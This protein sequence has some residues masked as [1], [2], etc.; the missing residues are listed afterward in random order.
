MSGS[1]SKRRR[2]TVDSL[3]Q[4]TSPRA[5]GVR[6]LV[7]AKE[8]N[9]DRVEPDPEQ[10][11]QTF[12]EQSLEELATSIQSEGVLQPIAVSYDDASDRYVIIHGERRWRAAKLAG[13][14]TVPAVV[15]D[16]P[17]ERRLVQQLME[18]VVRED[19][20]AVDRAAALRSLK[21]QMD[22]APWESVAEVVGIR[23]SRLFQLLSTE[24]LAE[25]V[26][27]RIRSGELSE[28]QTRSLQGLSPD[29][30]ETLADLIVAGDASE[31]TVRQISRELREDPEYLE[32][33]RDQL[34][35]RIT[36]L[37]VAHS[38]SPTDG[39]EHT[40]R[41]PV[42]TALGELFEERNLPDDAGNALSELA[43]HSGSDHGENSPLRQIGL[44][45]GR[46]VT[47]DGDESRSY[48]PRQ[49]RAL[50]AL[51]DLAL[52]KR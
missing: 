29:A 45:L 20:N 33:D 50:R 3:F 28:K 8:I 30:Q 37:C 49:L 25:P 13:L 19:L 5:V 52:R 14:S 6:D 1:R 36:E 35:D 23:R 18:N 2:F 51:I 22:N 17:E 10:P 34:R 9:I 38:A 40:T 7:N 48:T 32:L 41:D 27:E 16:I 46:M 31:R 44:Q 42:V 24:K 4:D 12:D 43:T 21:R 26:Q 39:G 11:R 15:R 47:G